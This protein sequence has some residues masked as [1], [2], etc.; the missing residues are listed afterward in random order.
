MVGR[1][2][3]CDVRLVR[4]DGLFTKVGFGIYILLQGDTDLRV[5][6]QADLEDGWMMVWIFCIRSGRKTG[7]VSDVWAFVDGPTRLVGQ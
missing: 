1:T 4:A 5:C 3:I 2:I 7:I 6:N